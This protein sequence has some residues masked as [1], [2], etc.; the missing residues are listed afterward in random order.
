MAKAEKVLIE[1]KLLK[2]IFKTKFLDKITEFETDISPIGVVFINETE[3]DG[4]KKGIPIVWSHHNREEIKNGQLH[5]E[6]PNSELMEFFIK[7][8]EEDF[9]ESE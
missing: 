5:V 8:I 7:L 3:I 2:S 9:D 6:S 4:D 1:N